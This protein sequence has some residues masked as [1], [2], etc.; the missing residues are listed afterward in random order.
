MESLLHGMFGEHSLTKVAGVF[1]QQAA[2][3]AALEQLR[4]SAGLQRTQVRLL[5]PEDAEGPYRELFGRTPEAHPTGIERILVHTH[6]LGALTGAALGLALYM[7]LSRASNAMVSGSPLVT[8]VAIVGFGITFGL[9]VAGL[10]AWR[11]DHVMLISR[12]RTALLNKR[13]VILVQPANRSERA[14]AKQ[15][16]LDSNAEVL[17][18]V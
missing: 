18:T 4:N 9:L 8:F 5:R 15:V 13:W 16:L 11:P 17:S 2:A 14:R 6:I 12:L 3:E 1:S 10:L 7:W